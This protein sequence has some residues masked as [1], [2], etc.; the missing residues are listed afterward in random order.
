M[1]IWA[2]C[3]TYFPLALSSS[4][5][6]ASF[7]LHPLLCLCL[8]LPWPFPSLDHTPVITL[9]LLS[10]ISNLQSQF[11]SGVLLFSPLAISSSLPRVSLD[12]TP[13]FVVLIPLALMCLHLFPYALAYYRLWPLRYLCLLPKFLHWTYPLKASPLFQPSLRAV[14]Y[15]SLPWFLFTPCRL[16]SFVLIPSFAVF[17]FA[18]TITLSS[19]DLAL[20]LIFIPDLLKKS[21]LFHLN[22]R[23]AIYLSGPWTYPL[24]FR[25]QVLS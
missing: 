21:P 24:L 2:W 1:S 12:A 11:E 7:Q 20:T 18:I 10:K 13:F 17:L 22:L 16:T 15:L 9:C 3:F 5:S 6:L 4:S 19:I 23:V 14:S 25:L 8:V